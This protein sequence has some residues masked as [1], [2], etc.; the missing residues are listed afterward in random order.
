MASKRYPTTLV[1]SGLWDR[2][3]L[4]IGKRKGMRRGAIRESLEEAMTMWL[5][6]HL[7]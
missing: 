1:D 3:V 6:D 2:F 4:E 7:G 5:G